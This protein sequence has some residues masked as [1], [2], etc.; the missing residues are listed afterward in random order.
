[1][2]KAQR[3]EI[4][5]DLIK[6]QTV[7]GNEIIVANYLKDLF[8]KNGIDVELNKYDED[9]YNLIASIKK[10]DGLFLVSLVT[11]MSSLLLTII[12]G[13]TVPSILNTSMAKSSAVAHLT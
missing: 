8:E 11:R 10:G 7:N 12:S 9:R 5:D 3:L 4:L 13:I 2:D 1:M 6:L